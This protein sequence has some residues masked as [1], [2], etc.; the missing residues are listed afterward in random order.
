MEINAE[1]EKMPIFSSKDLYNFGYTASILS[2]AVSDVNITK[3]K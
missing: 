3:K 2:Q 1:M